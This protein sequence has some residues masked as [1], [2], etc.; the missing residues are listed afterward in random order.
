MNT[1]VLQ[2][3]RRFSAK[4]IPDMDA[5][6]ENAHN[7][8]YSTY[9]WTCFQVC[10]LRNEFEAALCHKV[11]NKIYLTQIFTAAQM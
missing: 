10:P 9:K 1:P 3:D 7:S 6:M 8:V 2:R 4:S 5:D 11:D